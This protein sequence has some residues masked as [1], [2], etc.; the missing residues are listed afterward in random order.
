MTS[1]KSDPASV[2]LFYSYSHKD[3]AL[4]EEL[5]KHLSLLKRQNILHDWHDRQISAGRE[6]EGAINENLEAADIILLLVSSDFLASSYCYDKE[7]TRAL[8]KHEAG[9]ACVIPLI[10]RPVYW[11]GAPFSKLQALP[12]DGKPVTI[13]PNREEAWTDVTKG[14]ARAIEE[15]R[16]GPATPS[17]AH[18]R[19]RG[20]GPWW[21]V[22]Y[23]HNLY[24]TGRE[25]VFQQLHDAL[26]SR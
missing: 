20:E 1:P 6:W 26:I 13:W 5:E 22:P 9:E 4:R 24:F 17:S 3:E 15:L 11:S 10:V 19:S 21:K 12:E 2:R 7:M 25:K 8:E 14:I 16:T 18:G 23:P